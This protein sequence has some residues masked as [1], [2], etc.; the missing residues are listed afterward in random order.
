V[1]SGREKPRI[2]VPDKAKIYRLLEALGASKVAAGAPPTRGCVFVRLAL[3]SGMRASELR[4]LRV[5]DLRGLP[6]TSSGPCFLP[7]FCL[8]RGPV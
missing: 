6:I 8:L 4:C 3:G 1:K 2:E 7:M 5:S